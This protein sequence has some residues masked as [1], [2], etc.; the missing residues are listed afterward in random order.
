MGAPSGEVVETPTADMPYKVVI[1]HEGGIIRE[2]HFASRTAA[3]VYIID[4]LRGLQTADADEG[5]K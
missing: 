4:A 2:Q 3:E 5:R 1:S